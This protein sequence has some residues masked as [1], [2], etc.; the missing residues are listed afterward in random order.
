MI[1]ENTECTHF[2]PVK[3][4]LCAGIYIRTFD[5]VYSILGE[6][7]DIPRWYIAEECLKCSKLDPKVRK[8]I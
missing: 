7:V 4:N 3:D 6:E 5:T 8:Y 2:K 1:V